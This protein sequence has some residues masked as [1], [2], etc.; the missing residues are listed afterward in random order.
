[1]VQ[2]MM[3]GE[4][5]APADMCWTGAAFSFGDQAHKQPPDVQMRET[6]APRAG[7]DAQWVILQSARAVVTRFLR[8]G[9]G[10]FPVQMFRYVGMDGVS[11][12]LLVCGECGH[13][14]TCSVMDVGDVASSGCRACHAQ[15]SVLGCVQHHTWGRCQ[16]CR[17]AEAGVP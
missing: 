8:V 16:T 7:L 12:R 6:L 3:V 1:M 13:V 4:R 15:V 10:E 14:A 11:R 5:T 2:T 17:L 9:V